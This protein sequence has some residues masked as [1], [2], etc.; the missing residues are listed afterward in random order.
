MATANA[1]QL[2]K[3]RGTAETSARPR[4]F[5]RRLR[6]GSR[7]CGPGDEDFRELMETSY[8]SFKLERAGELDAAFHAKFESA[9]RR[10]DAYGAFQYDVV[11]AGGKILS[12]TFVR[13]TLLGAPGIT[14]KYLGLRI[15]AHP[16]AAGANPEPRNG[17]EGD[18]FA[19]M[20]DIGEL[21]EVL[22]GRGAAHLEERSRAIGMPCGSTDFNLT[23][24]NQMDGQAHAPA[25]KAEPL[26]GMGKVSVSWHADS[27]L[28]DF[29]TIAVYQRTDAPGRADWKV[30]LR[31]SG[32][33]TKTPPV[34][35]PTASGDLYW[36]LDSFNHHHEHAVL[37]GES[38]RY[39]STH[40]VAKEGS[41]NVHNVLHRCEKVLS[42]QGGPERRASDAVVRQ[43]CQLQDEVEFEWLRQWHI[44]GA[45]HAGLHR[46]WRKPMRRLK[47]H[48]E[49]LDERCRQRLGRL[50]GKDAA[51]A[52]LADAKALAVALEDRLRKR[53]YWEQRAADRVF[54]TLPEQHRPM[55][56]AL[57]GA[58]AEDCRGQLERARAAV[59]RLRA[60][61]GKGGA[62]GKGGATGASG[63]AGSNWAALQAKLKKGG[64]GVTPKRPREG[65]G[66]GASEAPKKRRA[67]KAPRA[68]QKV[69]KK[70]KSHK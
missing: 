23:L 32:E 42:A 24:I 14:Y 70:K 18:A 28:Q 3:L 16:F 36:M 65:A 31:V 46:W 5:P 17:V 55:P 8:P 58:T 13:R 49:K 43:E 2:R 37:A 54:R 33:E 35:L 21:N 69:K 22:K 38:T 63:G 45:F 25:L 15:F 26:F 60:A 10:L 61:R 68:K 53:E 4:E 47:A 52:R 67:E 50:A 27:G 11:Q 7:F 34:V 6:G 59:R 9:L 44:Q 39:S 1:V 29:S 40:R 41:H 12:K 62:A 20:A 64:G 51:P 30:A 48:W 19:A 57:P 56:F 66:A